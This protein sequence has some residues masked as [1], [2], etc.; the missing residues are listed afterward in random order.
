M[1]RPRKSPAL[2]ERRR[3]A[4]SLKARIV[5]PG[6]RIMVLSRNPKLYSTSRLVAAGEQL[7]Q[8]IRVIDTLECAVVIEQGRPLVLH[9]G[10]VL[11]DVDVV[12]P[13]F[14]ASITSYGLSIVSQF[15]MMGIPVVNGSAAIAHSR[16]KLRGLQLLSHAGI[17]VPRTVMARGKT[18][19]DDAVRRVGGLPTI[20]KLTQ[21]T[22]GIGVMIAHSMAEIGSILE[23]MRDLGQELLIQEFIAES[24]GH[25]VRVLVV[26]GR[27]VGAMRR[28]AKKGD[29]RSNLHRGGEGERIELTP[30]YAACAVDAAKV[31]GLEVA[32]IDLLET[33]RGPRVLEAN[34]SPGFEGLESATGI[35][36]AGLI[37]AHAARRARAPARSAAAG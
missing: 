30:E 26:A 2:G 10:R 18:D 12:I 23:T 14:G 16:D 20:V 13:R 29:F 31:L 35:D 9:E 27:A 5:P 21:G 7:G 1:R 22:Q 3:K 36:V 17:P 15:E 33:S 11:D 32:G 8:H 19:V 28:K 4:T 37:I 6:R 24:K 34:S 25:D